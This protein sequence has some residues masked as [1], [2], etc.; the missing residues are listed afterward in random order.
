M[1]RLKALIEAKPFER[2]ITGLILL[3][4]VTLGMETSKSIMDSAWG[5]VILMIDGIILAIFV[6]EIIARI[7]VHRLAFFRDPWSLFD[8]A[9]V[10]IALVPASGPL[11]V[12]RALRVLRVL[13]LVTVV[14]SLRKVVAA[15]I[16]ALPA[17]AR[18]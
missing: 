2:F 12:L 5:P 15:L 14:P 8:L 16:G 4:A 11:S 10:V 17:W 7:A 18:S 6:V 13:R 1:D 9:V 3:N